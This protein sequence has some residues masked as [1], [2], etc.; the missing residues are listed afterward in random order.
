MRLTTPWRPPKLDVRLSRLNST[1]EP[2]PR[3]NWP[4]S[5]PEPTSGCTTQTLTVPGDLLDVVENLIRQETPSGV[6]WRACVF[7]VSVSVPLPGQEHW[8]EPLRRGM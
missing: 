7:H 5:L 4:S 3:L 2:P 8:L 6:R 1:S